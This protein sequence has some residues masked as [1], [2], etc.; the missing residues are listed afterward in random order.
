MEGVNAGASAREFVREFPNLP[1]PCILRILV[2]ITGFGGF[3][4]L[5]GALSDRNDYVPIMLETRACLRTYRALKLP[6]R[7]P[8]RGRLSWLRPRRDLRIANACHPL[9]AIVHG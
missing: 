2:L 4:Q 6:I 9:A 1:S 8:V 7:Q 3:R 5:T